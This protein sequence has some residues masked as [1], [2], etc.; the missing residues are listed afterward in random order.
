MEDI[1][2]RI[3]VRFVTCLMLLIC[4]TAVTIPAFAQHF[5][6][7]DGS[8]TQI[9]VGRAEVWGLNGSEIYRF[10]SSTEKFNKIS[11]SL[12]QIAV[13]GGSLFLND[14]VWGVN[15]SGE[16][17]NFNFSKNKFV[18]VPG[19]L[20]QIAV[21][22]GDEDNCH[23]HEVW[24]VDPG[25]NFWRYNYCE[26]KFET[27]GGPASMKSISIGPNDFWGLDENSGIWV[28]APIS[29]IRVFGGLNNTL[30]QISVG[31]NDI[32]GTDSNGEL[33][34]YNPSDGLMDNV[35]PAFLATA[36]NVGQI[37]AGGDGVWAVHSYQQE[38]FNYVGI[39]QLTFS[40]PSTSSSA[41]FFNNVFSMPADTGSVV[42]IAVG[43]GGGVWAITSRL[44]PRFRT[45][46]QVY[47]WVRP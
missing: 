38:D 22:E 21:G 7:I 19:T 4:W 31:V 41:E 1:M 44:G 33:Y 8:L 40:T 10:D 37:A 11:G 23:F 14:E 43:S 3:N 13:G 5:K 17:F 29:A 32:W 28:L 46:Y 9:A 39:A 27:E 36:C 34:R 26:S 30:R 20:K 35:C 47:A 2:S 25:G 24:G 15:A 16:V 42:Q 18:T 45:S 12:T 6:Q